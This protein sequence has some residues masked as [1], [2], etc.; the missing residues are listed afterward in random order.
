MVEGE[1]ASTSDSVL[2]ESELNLGKLA[3]EKPLAQPPKCPQC[4]S[5]RIWRDGLRYIDEIP[6]QRWLCR[7]CG[8]RFSNSEPVQIVHRQVLNYPAGSFST[9]QVCD[10]E[11]E[12]SKNL[13]EEIITRQKTA[14]GAT[15]PSSSL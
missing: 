2:G 1:A 15:N 6:V 14:A 11:A 7:D 5:E 13:E 3:R 4:H 8:Y 12:A 9:C 10:C